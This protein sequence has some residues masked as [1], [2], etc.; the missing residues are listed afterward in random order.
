M[1]K[2]NYEREMQKIIAE[3]CLGG[4]KSRL[5]LHACCAPCA[6]SV[7]ERLKDCF[8]LTL[9]FYNPNM[10]ARSEYEARGKEIEKLAKAF[11]IKY[12]IEEYNANEFLEIASGLEKER[13]GGARCVK[14][15]NLR[16]EKSAKKAKVD[17]YDFFA[18]TLTVSPLKNAELLNKI[19]EKIAEQTGVKYLVSDFKKKNGYIR[20]IELSKELNLYRQNYCG[21]KFSKLQESVF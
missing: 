12:I 5:L 1:N 7:V 2:L 13:E 11:G 3:N 14:C 16:L 10:D 6:S 21:C 18:T 17:G 20:S 19:G 15:F 9:Y 8:D 4:N